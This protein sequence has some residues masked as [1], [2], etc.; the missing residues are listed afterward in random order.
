[1][2]KL[3][4]YFD[5]ASPYSYLANTQVP[6]L[7]KR[8]GAE[9]VYRPVLLGAIIVDSKNTPPPSVPAKA[10]YLGPDIQR[11]V[12]RYQIPFRF[13]P[14]FPLNSVRLLRGALVALEDG[15]F[16]A[17]HEAMFRAV[18]VAGT[19]LS[20]PRNIGKIARSSGLDGARLLER[21]EE[22]AIKDRL[23]TDTA[24][25]VERGLFGLPTFFVGDAMF[26]GNDRLD[27]V[28]EALERS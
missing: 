19:D 7:A 25:A 8:T 13:N 11:W 10:R 9:V 16:E 22:P 4:Y 26:F 23:K 3:D 6:G 2:A 24:A 1:M 20:D 28:E 5:Y 15:G 14:N 21:I 18:W 12:A 17:Y 27:F